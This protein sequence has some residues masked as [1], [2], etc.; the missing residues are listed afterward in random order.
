[1]RQPGRTVAARSLSILVGCTIAWQIAAPAHAQGPAAAPVAVEAVVAASATSA[2]PGD[3]FLVFDATA[4]AHV[5]GGLDLIVRPY[6]HRLTGGDWTA[7]MYQLQLRY[8][9]RT[10]VPYR[11][12]AGIIS[13]PLGLTTLELIPG[14]NPTIAAPFF[15]F[16]PL[17]SFEPGFTGVQLISGGYPLGAIVSSSGAHWDAR[18]GLTDQTP[19]RRRNVLDSGRPDASAQ[20]VAGGGYTP[21]A[22]LRFGAGFGR[23]HYR[24][25]R[26]VAETAAPMPAR[27]ATVVT[28]EAEYAIGY[29]RFAGEWIRSSFDTP[30]GIALARGFT[31]EMV[32]TLGPRWFAA[33]RVNRASSPAFTI[34]GLVRRDAASGEATLGYR[35]SQTLTLRGAY[36]QSRFFGAASA[37]RAV[38]MS[39]VWSKRWW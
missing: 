9:S 6:A 33:A 17:P 13:S 15:Y 35:L 39:A 20:L 26:V 34:D 14:R 4:T 28:L 7:E 31:A 27:D 36:Q 21:V 1:M 24:P 32:R 25:S 2:D 19:A 30:S 11:V 18:A 5:R 38:A 3:P 37:Q 8:I 16:A 22:G 10:R 12:D 29:S 23:G